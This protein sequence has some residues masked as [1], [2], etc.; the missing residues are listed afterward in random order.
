ME[1]EVK[2]SDE[3]NL[4]DIFAVCIKFRKL[5]LIGT[6]LMFILL[7]GALIGVSKIKESRTGKTVTVLNLLEIKDF[8]A[9]FVE[10]KHDLNRVEELTRNYLHDTCFFAKLQEQYPAWADPTASDYFDKIDEILNTSHYFQID[11]HPVTDV[12]YLYST[13]PVSRQEN[14]SPFLNAYVNHIQANLAS[15][16]KSRCNLSAEDADA[17]LKNAEPF[18]KLSPYTYQRKPASKTLT[19]KIVIIFLGSLFCF[20]FLAFVLNA[21]QAVKKDENACKTLKE[22]WDNGK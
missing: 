13:V 1:N 11:F 7:T 15:D 6:A 5:I 3:V 9:E 20:V 19:L 14:L 8:P 18:V 21:V 16:F 4:I 2:K 10:S 17:W 22:A 12:F